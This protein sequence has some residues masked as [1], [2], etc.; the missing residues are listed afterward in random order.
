VRTIRALLVRPGEDSRI[1]EIPADTEQRTHEELSGLVGGY[2]EVVMGDD[3]HAYCDEDGLAKDLPANVFAARLLEELNPGRGPARICGPVVFLGHT[4]DGLEYDVPS[5]IEDLARRMTAGSLLTNWTDE[6][7][8]SLA[9]AS[10]KVAQTLQVAA[11]IIRRMVISYGWKDVANAVPCVRVGQQVLERLGHTAVPVS[12]SFMALSELCA[13]TDGRQGHCIGVLG[14]GQTDP[15]GP[16]G[17]SWDGHLALL[18]DGVW[19]LD[20]AA[21]MFDRPAH[22]IRIPEAFLA[23]LPEPHPGGLEPGTRMATT[24]RDG[25]VVRYTVNA[26]TSWRTLI[27]W[28][29]RGERVEKA[30]MEALRLIGPYTRMDDT[31]GGEEWL[32]RPWYCAT[33][34]QGVRRMHLPDGTVQYA[35]ARPWEVTDGHDVMPEQIDDIS[36]VKLVCDFCLDPDPVWSY[37]GPNVIDE[38]VTHP[39]TGEV[40]GPGSA[41]L[42][43]LGTLWAG[44]QI[45]DRYVQAG[46]LEG[47]A[48]SVLRSK[49]NRNSS[50]DP[51]LIAEWWRTNMARWERFVPHITRRRLINPPALDPV[52][53]RNLPKVRARLVRFL[54]DESLAA[55]GQQAGIFMLPGPDAGCPDDMTVMV[56]M[57][58]A[59]Q[60]K[61]YCDRIVRGLELAELYH[62]SE[63]FTGLALSSGA[64]LTDLSVTPEELPCPDGLV[65]WAVPIMAADARH[66][67]SA[68][69]AQIIAASWT[70]VSGLGVWINWYVRTDQID[71]G[72]TAIREAAGVLLPW[73]NGSGL[74]F[75]VTVTGTH[76]EPDGGYPAHDADGMGSYR[77]LLATWFLIN[78]P[79]VAQTTV[80]VSND[81]QLVKRAARAGHPPPT[82]R[83]VDLRHSRHRAT[84]AGAAGAGRPVTV[85][86]PVRGHWRRQA[87]GPKRGM[88]RSMYI[89]PFMKGPEGAPLKTGGT[90]PVVRVLK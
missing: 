79:G 27:D 32:K 88:R 47:L 87:Y 5:R 80:Q 7:A 59:E 3:W 6:G 72:N 69:E 11:S 44:C 4:G 37:T 31:Y 52:N 68:D 38:A 84:A 10:G 71:P 8:V 40:L 13:Q 42:D 75:G 56:T 62:V 12:V 74:K 17:G 15:H 39:L 53:P 28:T 66:T 64:D 14:T 85:R 65:M 63:D 21:P 57:P 25:S 35:H 29:G 43:G 22:G 81:K 20:I 77:T 86:F 58:S 26:L 51:R 18:V 1:A 50:R 73:A 16:D 24:R 46:D 67:P 2:L 9:P 54:S 33:C 76:D 70:T 60:G 48:R 61:A 82:V 55:F 30:A 49:A 41:G 89:A 19:L 90:V 23:R 36:R 78:Q 45:C 83:I 34:R